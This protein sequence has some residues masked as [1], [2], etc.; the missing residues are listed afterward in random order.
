MPIL[1][2]DAGGCLSV[3]LSAR[4]HLQLALAL[5]LELLTLPLASQVIRLPPGFCGAGDGARMYLERAGQA[6][7]QWNPSMKSIL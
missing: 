7:C 5:H 4:P 1:A 6:I 3:C 2:E